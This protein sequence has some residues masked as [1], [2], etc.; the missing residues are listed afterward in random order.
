MTYSITGG[1]DAGKFSINS[2][3]GALIFAAAPN[4]ESPT[5]N[6][7]NNIYD[8]VVEVTDGSLTDSQSIAVTVTNDTEPPVANHDSFSGNSNSTIVGNVLT[9]DANPDGGSLT[10]LDYTTPTSGTSSVTSAGDLTYTPVAGFTGLDGLDYI[11][12][13]GTNGPTHYWNLAGQASDSVGGANGILSDTA[14]VV[15]HYGDGLSFPA[16][17]PWPCCLMSLT[18]TI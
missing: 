16:P 5:D 1:A 9:N 4:F 11:I 6:G 13:D 3:S 7:S 17:Q 10:V 14:T 12:S 15:G 8:V 18:A 2:S